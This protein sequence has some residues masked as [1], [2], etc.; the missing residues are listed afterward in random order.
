MDSTKKKT[1]VKT[2]YCQETRLL[3]PTTHLPESLLI[4]VSLP[5]S[6]YSMCVFQVTQEINSRLSFVLHLYLK[7]MNVLPI[8]CIIK[9]LICLIISMP[10]PEHITVA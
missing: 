7:N 8:S 1:G 10:S 3:S 6:L 2:Q 5:P 9:V 4:C